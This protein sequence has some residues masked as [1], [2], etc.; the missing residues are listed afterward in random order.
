MKPDER[1]PHDTLDQHIKEVLRHSV[2]NLLPQTADPDNLIA[3]HAWRD[4]NYIGT[5]GGKVVVWRGWRA[6]LAPVDP[7]YRTLYVD[8]VDNVL[9]LPER[10]R[11]FGNDFARA[12]AGLPRF[13]VMFTLGFPLDVR[14]NITAQGFVP[15]EM[16]RVLHACLVTG[17]E[18]FL[19]K[20]VPHWSQQG[21]QLLKLQS[22]L[23]KPGNRKT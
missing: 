7:R 14:E 20:P 11:L 15:R 17:V 6:N 23:G 10:Q 2:H 1:S 8:V 21:A 9:P 3:P 19:G 5:H 22:E 4:S 16:S 13:V 12:I 18:Q